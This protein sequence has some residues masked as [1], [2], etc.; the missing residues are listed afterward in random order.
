MCVAILNDTVL[1]IAHLLY[2]Y[3]D[4]RLLMP[5]PTALLRRPDELV[6]AQAALLPQDSQFAERITL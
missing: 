2:W 5:A 3:A 4:D 6:E 1:Q